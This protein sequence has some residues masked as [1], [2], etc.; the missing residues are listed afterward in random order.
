MK[1]I[2][3]SADIE[4][5]WGN[6]NPAN[7]IKSGTDYPEYAKNMLEEVNLLIDLLFKQGVQTIVVND[8]HGNMDNIYASQIDKR[9][10]II[11]SHG[12]Y[13]EY[14]MM[15][16]FDETFDGICFV[17]YH[18]K[19]NTPGVMSH[20]I[21]GSMISKIVLD[22][23]E[24][25]ESGLNARLAWEYGVPI[26][27][28][29]GDNLLKEQLKEELV[30]GYAYVETK[31]ALSSQCALCCSK[32]ELKQRYETA[33]QT[34]QKNVPDYPV[35]PHTM[36]ITFHHIRNADFVARMDGVTKIDHCTVEIQKDSYND[37]YKYMRF[38]IKVCNA[39][40]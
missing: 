28:V 22:G 34:M 20:T 36:Q 27:L 32:N 24:L 37:L 35:K 5:I 25:G 39:F 12:A 16:G 26:V 2:Y 15:E 18:C 3:I 33:V 10:Q 21:W 1:K 30:P 6:A 31:K 40:A 17:G 7:T 9:A 38:V 13:K 4:G 8:S 29:S 19:S 14:G 23:Q 11:I